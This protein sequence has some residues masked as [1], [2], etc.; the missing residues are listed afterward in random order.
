MTFRARI[1]PRKIPISINSEDHISVFR[2]RILQYILLGSCLFG[3]ITLATN[4]STPISRGLWSVVI[5]YTTAY[6]LMVLITFLR[7]LSLP[8]RTAFFLLVLYLLSLS[9]LFDAG[10]SGTGRVFLLTFV[11]FATVLLGNRQGVFAGIAAVLTLIVFGWLMSSNIIPQPPVSVMANSINFDQWISETTDFLL[12]CV[13]VTSSII[14][15]TTGLRNTI[16]TQVILSDELTKERN[17]LEQTVQE[18]ISEI[19]Q[20]ATQVETASQIA[21]DISILSNLDDLLNNA[22]NLIHD[23]F[24]YY[25]AGIFL[26]DEHNEFAVLRAATGEAGRTMIEWNHRLRV[27]EI[28]IVGYVVAQGESRVSLDVSEDPVHFK[29][30]ILPLTRSEAA[31]PL[32]VGDQIIGAL[33]VQS[34]KAGA[35]GPDD[36]K[37]LQRIADQLAVAVE[38]TR[39]VEKLQQSVNELETSYQ[40]FTQKSWRAHLKATHRNY[41]YRYRQSKI[42]EVVSDNPEAIQALDRKEPVITSSIDR[43][44]EEKGFVVV[45]LPIKLRNQVLGVVDIQ[46]EGKTIPSDVVPMLETITNR[47]A[48]ALENARL[49]EQTVRRAERERKVLEITSKIRS[50]NDPQ[51][52]LRVALEELQGALKASRAQIVLQPQTRETIPTIGGNGNGLS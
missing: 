37:I 28:G 39:L 14:V 49:F 5:A 43:T 6:L 41:N 22:V 20:R 31:L 12:L 47:L 32:I 13:A 51:Q 18:R 48:L 44:N 36:V 8:V 9:S 21:R 10:L 29:N 52:M 4:L 23:R 26:L 17:A 24:G 30:P 33:D 3:L 1:D 46:F 35:F 16:T 7:N 15:L 38:K 2:D 45:A 27:G 40:T 50:T 11:V 42:D 25:H 19:Q 34:E